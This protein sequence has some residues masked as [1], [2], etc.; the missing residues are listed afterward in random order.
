VA[1]FSVLLALAVTAL[2]GLVPLV[3][4]RSGGWQAR[5]QTE[6]P[7]SRRLRHGLVIAEVAIAIVVVGIAGLLAR[8]VS[9]LRAVDVG[10]DTGH[11]IVVKTDLT[12][13][14]LRERGAAARFTNEAVERLA[15][16]PGVSAVG[17]TTGVPFEGEPARQAITREGDVI[18]PESESPRLVHTAVTLGYFRA[19]SIALVRGR[20]FTADDRAEG[21]LVAVINETAARRYWPG[22]D[23]IGKRFAI[24]SRERF[25]SFRALRPGEVEWREIVGVVADIR[26][27]GFASDVQPEVFY[28]TTQFPL[29]DPSFAIRTS[30]AP[31]PS[32]ASIRAALTSINPRAVIVRVRTMD[33]IAQASIADPRLRAAAATMF[34][35]VAL[36]L[37]MLGIYALMAYTVTQQHREIGIRIALGARR[38]QVAR[39]I[40]GKAVRLAAA[41]AALGVLG[42]YA[43]ARGISTLLFGV[44]PGDPVVLACACG[45]LIAAA[46]VAAVV[47]ARRAF[48]VD[49]AVTLRSE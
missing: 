6:S 27:A 40:V 47:P 32:T 15:A 12:T 44:G 25:G 45:V 46:A 35:A 24:G 5:G 4:W 29:F 2:C 14:P 38:D 20:A 49:P 37:G 11:T 16:L 10:F 1:G 18:R 42:A 9:N 8:T 22:E 41:G 48:D 3:E 39:M 17:A 30:G 7:G 28:S 31:A 21:T 26:S 19:M 43:V 33:E 13:T 36:L 34:S 23:P